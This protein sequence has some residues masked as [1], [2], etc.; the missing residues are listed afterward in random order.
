M[1]VRRISP[2]FRA[3]AIASTWIVAVVINC[4]DLYFFGLIKRYD[5]KMTCLADSSSL[6]FT[7]YTSLRV[8]VIYIA[9]MFLVTILYSVIAVTL[10]RRDK[11]LQCSTTQRNDVKKRQAIKMSFCV[12]V[13][14]CLF[15]LPLLMAVIFLMTSVSKSCSFFHHFYLFSS[16]ALHLSSTTNPIICFM[17]VESF[18]RALR[19]V[20]NFCLCKRF[21]TR[22]TEPEN[23]EQIIL[24]RIKVVSGIRREE[25][26]GFNEN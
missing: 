26:L 20:F 17:F 25:N 21:R 10:R 16:S 15:F 19:D 24:K 18:R 14:F 9:P 1:R 7:I 3:F 23:G 22:T 2:R 8:V 6:L 12:V 4:P 5:G 13:S 11:V